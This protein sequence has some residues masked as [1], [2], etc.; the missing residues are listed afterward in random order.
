MTDKDRLN[1]ESFYLSQITQQLTT[2]SVEQENTIIDSHPRFNY[3]CNEYGKPTIARTHNSQ[4]DAASLAARLLR[5]QI[6]DQRITAGTTTHAPLQVEIPKSFSV[7]SLCGIV[8]KKLGARPMSTRLIWETGEKVPKEQPVMGREMVVEWD[9]ED[10]LDEA[11]SVQWVEREVELIPSTRPL[12]TIIDGCEAV[13]RTEDS[14]KP[15]P[16]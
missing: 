3:L 7:Y 2:A 16:Q 11:G 13:L 12:G 9:S 10:E 15:R 5:C 14:V 1:A 8:N 6:S 4:V